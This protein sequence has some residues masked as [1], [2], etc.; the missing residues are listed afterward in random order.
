MLIEYTS[1]TTFSRVMHLRFTSELFRFGTGFE[2]VFDHCSHGGERDKATLWWCSDA[3]FM[4]LAIRCTRDHDHAPWRPVFQ[5]GC[6]Q[7]PTTEEAAYP[8]LLCQRI[9]A[10]LAESSPGLA[11]SCSLV[12]PP[13]QIALEDNRAMQSLW[14][15]PS[16]D[17][18]PG[19][20][21]SI[22]MAPLQASSPAIPRDPVS[23]SAN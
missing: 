19:P 3:L 14:F 1:I 20:F 8:W 7:F 22:T 4:P 5:D 12:R 15:L 13:E 23:L 16:A 9:A 18:I 21:P 11:E 2:C 10:L 17:M 6:W